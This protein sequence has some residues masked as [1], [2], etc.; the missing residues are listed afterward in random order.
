MSICAVKD[1]A[2]N[3]ARQIRDAE[4]HFGTVQE[5]FLCEGFFLDASGNVLEGPITGSMSREDWEAL[6]NKY[7]AD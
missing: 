2:R 1:T 7:L 3:T 4:S 5:A 6:I